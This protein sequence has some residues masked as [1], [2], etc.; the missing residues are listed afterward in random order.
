MELIALPA[1]VAVAYFTVFVRVDQADRQGSRAMEIVQ[2]YLY[3]GEAVADEVSDDLET[4]QVLVRVESRGTVEDLRQ[5]LQVQRD[6]LSSGLYASS[7]P[8][9]L[10]TSVDTV[11]QVTRPRDE[12]GW[13]G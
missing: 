4:F 3:Q 12:G 9:I 1:P 2:R 6:R 8:V 7:E 11:G 13:G 10:A 5:R